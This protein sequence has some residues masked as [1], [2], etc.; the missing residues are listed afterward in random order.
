MKR[1][2]LVVDAEPALAKSAESA[3][4]AAGFELERATDG[5]D[6]LRRIE[7]NKPDMVLTDLLLDGMHGFEL[8]RRLRAEPETHHLPIWVV[9]S[10]NYWAD[11]R[12][13]LVLGAARIIRKPV[14]VEHLV[15]EL[16]RDFDHVRLKYWGVRGS[17][18]TPGPSTVKFGGNTPCV[19]VEH[20]GTSLVF[21]AGTGIRALGQE[22]L[23]RAKGEPQALALFLSHTHWDHIQGVPFFAPMFFPGNQVDIFGPSP[24]AGTLAD[25]LRRQMEAPYFPVT[26][27][28]MAAV[29]EV[30]ELSRESLDRGPF[31]ISCIY[32]NHPGPTLAYRIET[33]G[34]A[35]VYATDN[36][37]YQRLLA[38]LEGERGGGEQAQRSLDQVL[39][40]FVTGADLLV[41]DAQYSP[42]EYRKK[43]GWGHTSYLDAVGLAL[44]AGVKRLA[45]F[46]HDANQDDAAV[47]AKERDSQAYARERGSDLVVTSAAELDVIDLPIN[48]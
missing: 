9:S 47:A 40:K 18:P 45:L 48:E 30:T 36:E 17:I 3:L 23:A 4:R 1:R 6:A 16:H 35:I 29:V 33:N 25:V 34:V 11:L 39:T 14:D 22:L 2:L 10:Q 20:R 42:E 26:I 15:A 37:P 5:Q 19:S 44:A 7:Q 32:V 24:Q 8:I 43:V 13:A 41:C 12:K 21:D 28:D 27:R 31:R 46:S 38:N